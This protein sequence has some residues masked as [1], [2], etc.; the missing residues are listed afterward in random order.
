[1]GVG[2]LVWRVGFVMY[3]MAL[4]TATHWPG[5][6]IHGPVTRTD[7]VIHVGAFG[8]WTLGLG[9]TGWVRGWWVVAVGACF[10]V[11]DETTQPW[12]DRVFDVADLGAD[13]LGAI[14]GA[15]VMGVVGSIG[16]RP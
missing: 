3:T 10:G 8:A 7:L 1:M 11:L 14:V 16:G 5:L 4:V 6:A 15:G 9:L 12:F 2:S 13:V